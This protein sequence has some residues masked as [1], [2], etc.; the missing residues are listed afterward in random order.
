MEFTILTIFK[1]G[2]QW[3]WA[4]EHYNAFTFKYEYSLPMKR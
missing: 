2:V 4:I 1:C 3:C